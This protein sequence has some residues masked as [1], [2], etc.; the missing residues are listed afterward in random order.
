MWV[1]SG[2]KIFLCLGVRLPPGRLSILA[3]ALG[4][5]MWDNG[6]H[7]IAMGKDTYCPAAPFSR[8]P[9]LMDLEKLG[10]WEL[11]THLTHADRMI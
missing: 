8:I 3:L 9:T 2:V 10:T 11:D 5:S 6:G 7:D 1:W 4:E